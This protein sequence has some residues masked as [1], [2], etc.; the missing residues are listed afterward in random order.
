MCVVLILV[1]VFALSYSLISYSLF[2][3]CK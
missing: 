2:L 1:G 3:L